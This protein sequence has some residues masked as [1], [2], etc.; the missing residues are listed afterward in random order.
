MSISTY[1]ALRTKMASP[2]WRE[3]I[4]KNF[5][6]NGYLTSSWLTGSW[7]LAGTAPTTAGVPT[8][9]T[10]GALGQ[11]DSSGTM[12]MLGFDRLCCGG[13]SVI[14]VYDR[15]SHQGGLD[16]TVTS[17]QTTNLP[18]AALTR[19][20]SGVGVLAAL[21]IYS[22]IGTTSTTVSIKYTNTANTAG[23]VSPGRS[24]GNT[25]FREA[26]QFLPIPLLGGDLGV[27]SVQGVTLAGTTGTAGAFGVTLWMPLLSIVTPSSMNIAMAHQFVL[28]YAQ[29]CPA[30]TTAACIAFFS[31]T[32]DTGFPYYTGSPVF[33]ED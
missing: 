12:R 14:T 26:G 21:E 31:M 25:S 4:N 19:Y 29:A 17:E 27:K 28:D 3:L 22:A 15:L 23:R 7:P 5:N 10:L 20:T 30:I 2:Y 1:A 33:G 24:F 16:G 18:T 13:P 9:A 8:S 32:K 6:T 11:P